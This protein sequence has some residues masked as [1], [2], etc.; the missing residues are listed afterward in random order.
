MKLKTCAAVGLTWIA[1]AVAQA[2]PVQQPHSTAELLSE[3]A[4]LA[5]G[6]STTIGLRLKLDKNWHV[7]WKNPGDS[8]MATRINWT[9]PAGAQTGEIQWPVPHRID[10]GP[11]TSYGYSDEVVLLSTLSVPATFQGD[12]FPLKATADW[13]VCEEVCIPASASFD[14]TLLVG[15]E[16]RVAEDVSAAFKLTRTQFPG[17]PSGWRTQVLR[18]GQALEIVV[19][20]S[21]PTTLTRLAFHP[22]E[23]GVIE[24]NDTQIT[25]ASADGYRL[26][27]RQD[28]TASA[29][30]TLSGV[31]TAEPGFSGAAGLL[32]S[33]P[34]E[35]ATLAALAVPPAAANMTLALALVAAFIGGMILNLMPCVF[36]VLTIKILGVLER[37]H[38]R[39]SVLREQGALFTVGVLASFLVIAG[40]MLALRAQ[41]GALG[42]GFQLQSPVMVTGL[43]LLF[44]LLGLNMAGLFDIGLGAQSLAGNVQVKNEKLDALASGLL[45][46]L[47]ATPCTAPFMGAA[48][49]YAV[50]LPAATALLVFAAM[51]LGMALPY[52][53]L[54]LFP[55][56]LRKLPR[57]G[58]WMETL[59]QFLAFPLFATV[60]WL[61]WVLG[62]QVGID[63]AARVLLAMVLLACALWTRQR[64]R[65]N[66]WLRNAVSVVLVLGAVTL[67]WPRGE[68]GESE[69]AWKPWSEDA[70]RS[71]LDAGHP[72]FVDFTAAWCVSCQVNKRLV[73]H[74]DTIDAAFRTAQVVRLRADWTNRDASITAALEKLGRNG[75]P[76]YALFTPG[77]R[78]PRLLPEVLTTG[79]VKDA[80]AKLTKSS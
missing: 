62:Q 41:G 1:A 29:S 75:V 40:L 31:L 17:T 43:A 74:T 72:V 47:V 4:V 35:N 79:V 44:M 36:P 24:D 51:A 34:I 66:H 63:G 13:L 52:A 49:G 56:A 25:T 18:E 68:P 65:I 60:V 58:R 19:T 7:Y 39:R 23:E 28:A 16:A 54:C 38:G 76:V 6:Q 77:Q 69:Q 27:L 61:L 5:P 11:I 48:L 64:L 80:L 70:V 21:T 71:A 20:P 26:R 30:T 10:T 50:T 57:P 67:A 78:E 12:R 55:A 59:K 42:W 33:A 8:G 9:L 46:T 32:V 53:L 15:P 3:H 73:L 37:A 22:D 2:A 14:T 45:A